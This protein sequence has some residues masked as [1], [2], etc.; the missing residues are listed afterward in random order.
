MPRAP[1]AVLEHPFV[2]QKRA[3]PSVTNRGLDN[4]APR[5]PLSEAA[6]GLYSTDPTQETCA[7]VDD[8]GYTGPRRAT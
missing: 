1:S 7:T 3:S 2:F 4:L 6:Q 8:A 5:V